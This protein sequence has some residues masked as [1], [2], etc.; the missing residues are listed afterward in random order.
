MQEKKL[1]EKQYQ[2]EVLLT[3]LKRTKEGKYV[4]IDENLLSYLRLEQQRL[5]FE[6]EYYYSYR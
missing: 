1:K 4:K 5:D 2:E 3:F 6:D